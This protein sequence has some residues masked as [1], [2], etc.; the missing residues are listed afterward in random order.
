[1][2]T[3]DQRRPTMATED[4][5]SEQLARLG[6]TGMAARQEGYTALATVL[7]DGE[8]IEAVVAGNYEGQDGAAAAT[9]QRL[10]FVAASRGLLRRKARREEF[11]YSAITSVQ[12]QEGLI[13]AELK[14]FASG[15]SATIEGSPMANTD[16]RKFADHINQRV[17][18]ARAPSAPAAQAAAPDLAGQLE[19]LAKLRDQGILTDAEFEAQKQKLLNA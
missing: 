1:M 7:R 6:I 12:V 14:V 4:Q 17:A 8:Q 2:A 19:R 5:V 15:N 13:C 11:H 10:V 3:E 18:A 16:A 9:D